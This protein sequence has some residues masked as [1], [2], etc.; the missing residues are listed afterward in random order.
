M[1]NDRINP[2]SLR[3]DAG[4]HPPNTHT[5]VLA[6]AAA[7]AVAVAAPRGTAKKPQPKLPRWARGLK[8]DTMIGLGVLVFTI[9]IAVLTWFLVE[10]EHTKRVQYK[11]ETRIIDA[12]VPAKDLR[13]IVR[14]PE[15]TPAKDYGFKPI[16]QECKP[17]DLYGECLLDGTCRGT[18]A[19]FFDA[20]GKFLATVVLPVSG[21][22]EVRFVPLTTS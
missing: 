19:D 15:G 16:G 10:Q 8:V 22:L 9:L 11:I 2:A 14:P 5:H 13:V 12:S 17:T 1:N 20:A 21:H 7:D 4:S 6:A 18:S 3:S